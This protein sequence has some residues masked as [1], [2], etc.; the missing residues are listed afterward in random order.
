MLLRAIKKQFFHTFRKYPFTRWLFQLNHYVSD[1]K[2]IYGLPREKA[3]VLVMCSSPE[4]ETIGCGG[5]IGLYAQGGHAVDVLYFDQDAHSETQK[6]SSILGVRQTSHFK[7][8]PSHPQGLS[9]QIVKLFSETHYDSIFC[10]WPWPGIPGE[11]LNLFQV[12]QQALK[13]TSLHPEI[14]L[15]EIWNQLPANRLIPIDGSVL[16]KQKAIKAITKL[17]RTKHPDKKA[18]SVSKRRSF[19]CKESDFAEAFF[20]CNKEQALTLSQPPTSETFSPVKPKVQ[21]MATD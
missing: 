21:M 19:L 4:G 3:T 7:T 10:P 16:L 13:E 8:D 6:A 5:T 15:Y 18:L 11:G 20:F 1:V 9:Q 2:V 14:W 12:L 17:L